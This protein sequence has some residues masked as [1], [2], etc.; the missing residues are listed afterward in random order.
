MGFVCPL[1][2]AVSLKHGLGISLACEHRTPAPAL[3]ALQGTGAS[4]CAALGLLVTVLEEVTLLLCDH[5]RHTSLK[6]C[7]LYHFFLLIK[8]KKKKH[9]REAVK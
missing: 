9:Y 4:P 1:R 2:D 6:L 3:L 8:K 7:F 5:C